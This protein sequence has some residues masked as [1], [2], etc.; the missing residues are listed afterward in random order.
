MSESSQL[1]VVSCWLSEP[2]QLTIR[3]QQQTLNNNKGTLGPYINCESLPPLLIPNSSLL[4]K[5][6]KKHGPP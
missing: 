1:L 6:H 2:K 3:N 4:L 5:H